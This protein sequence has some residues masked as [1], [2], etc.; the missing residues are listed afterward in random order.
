MKTRI[1]Y[2]VLIIILCTLCT[3]IP[4]IITNAKYLYNVKIE[5]DVSIGTMVFNIKQ[6]EG[7]CNVYQLEKGGQI[8]AKYKLRNKDDKNNINTL[9]LKYYLKI[10]DTNQNEI[11]NFDILVNDYN[12][13]KYNVDE[14]GNI[15]N[16]DGDIVDE[17][18]QIVLERKLSEEENQ[19]L[20]Q[21]LVTIKKGYGPINLSC[22]GKTID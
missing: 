17:E 10:V 20:Q 16:E 14:K 6:L 19:N 11:D 4:V 13:V 1:K 8:V 9:D 15:I 22:D 7:E 18:G 5:S 2:F 3:I 21:S 12:Y